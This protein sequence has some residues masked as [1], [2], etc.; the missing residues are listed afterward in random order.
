MVGNSVNEITICAGMAHIMFKFNTRWSIIQGQN[1]SVKY[2][3]S[4]NDPNFH[5]EIL[6]PKLA[7]SVYQTFEII[8]I[9]TWFQRFEEI[10]D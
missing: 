1:E 6:G 9:F 2:I 5:G 3:S 10:I 4:T 7:T 8:L